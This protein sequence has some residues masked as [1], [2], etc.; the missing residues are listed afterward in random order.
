MEDDAA[1]AARALAEAA[2]LGHSLTIWPAAPQNIQS[3]LS[4]RRLRSSEV[5]FPSLLSFSTTGDFFGVEEE[6]DEDE[7]ELEEPEDLPEEDEEVLDV[8]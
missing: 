8:F 2:D 6:E 5:S 4:K 3:L 7:D 1:L